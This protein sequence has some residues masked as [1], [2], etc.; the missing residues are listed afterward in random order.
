MATDKEGSRKRNRLFLENNDEFII[1]EGKEDN[2]IT[3]TTTITMTTDTSS[4]QISTIASPNNKHK[5]WQFSEVWNYF[6]KGIEKSNGHYEAIC[7]YCRKKWARGKPAQLE[8]HLANECIGCSDYISQYWQEKVAERSP[9]YTRKSKEPY[10]LPLPNS[11]SQMAITSH[12]KSDYPLSKTII[13]RL[14]QKIIKAWIMA[15][16]PFDVIDNPFIRDMFKEFN[17]EYNS[18]SRTTLSNRLL[19]EKLA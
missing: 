17:P 1:S 12:Y 11:I 10:T 19:D 7:S 5:S 6:I 18:P 2:S 15:G 9:N 8:A 4:L 3:E 14:D 13:N 16:I